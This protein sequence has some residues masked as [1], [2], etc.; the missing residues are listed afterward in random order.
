MC[1]ALQ[2]PFPFDLFQILRPNRAK[3]YLKIT[4]ILC[5]GAL[6]FTCKSNFFEK[7]R[8]T[9]SSAIWNCWSFVRSSFVNL[10]CDSGRNSCDWQAIDVIIEKNRTLNWTDR[11]LTFSATISSSGTHKRWLN[12]TRDSLILSWIM[13][14]WKDCKSVKSWKCNKYSNVGTVVNWIEKKIFEKV[15]HQ[16][17]TFLTL[18][19]SSINS[20]IASGLRTSYGFIPMSILCWFK[21][22]LPNFTARF[23]SSLQN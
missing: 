5:I 13:I 23:G 7:C 3:K 22:K 4:R 9:D 10:T 17:K 12:R 11:A 2:Q 6:V 20:W 18:S 16:K 1:L 14:K 15:S 21:P 8:Y 19:N